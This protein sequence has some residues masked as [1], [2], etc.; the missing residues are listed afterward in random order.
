MPAT[1]ASAFASPR[2]DEHLSFK[3][4]DYMLQTLLRPCAALRFRFCDSAPSCEAASPHRSASAGPEA[5]DLARVAFTD[6]QSCAGLGFPY[7]WDEIRDAVTAFRSDPVHVRIIDYCITQHVYVRRVGLGG[8][9]TTIDEVTEI[10]EYTATAFETLNFLCDLEAADFDLPDTWSPPVTMRVRLLVYR[11][12]CLFLLKRLFFRAGPG[13][14]L[15][16]IPL[17]KQQQLRSAYVL[18]RTAA[19]VRADGLVVDA[20][21]PASEALSGEQLYSL[22][23]TT[24]AFLHDLVNNFDYRTTLNPSARPRDGAPEF[25]AIAAYVEDLSELSEAGAFDVTS[26]D[27]NSVV[28]GADGSLLNRAPQPTVSHSLSLHEM[29]SHRNFLDEPTFIELSKSLN[30]PLRFRGDYLVAFFLVLQAYAPQLGVTNVAIVPY[31]AAYAARGNRRINV[32]SISLD[33]DEQEAAKH[34]GILSVILER[35]REHC[36]ALWGTRAS[37]DPAS[38]PLRSADAAEA[39]DLWG[40]GPLH[41][42]NTTSPTDAF[43]RSLSVLRAAIHRMDFEALPSLRPFDGHARGEPST[44]LDHASFIA[45]CD[46]VPADLLHQISKRLDPD[47]SLVA[48]PSLTLESEELTFCLEG[49]RALVAWATAVLY[50]ESGPAQEAAD[51]GRSTTFA[52]A[53]FSRCYNFDPA[54]PDTLRRATAL[55]KSIL[56]RAIGSWFTS[57]LG[58]I[59]RACGGTSPAAQRPTTD[60]QRRRSAPL[61][62][63]LPHRD[64]R[65]VP[66]AAMSLPAAGSHGAPLAYHFVAFSGKC[67]VEWGAYA[68]DLGRVI[69]YAETSRLELTRDY[70]LQGPLRARP[71]A[72]EHGLRRAVLRDDCNGCGH[73]EEGAGP[74]REEHTLQEVATVGSDAPSAPY[75]SRSVDDGYPSGDRAAEARAEDNTTP[76]VSTI[77]GGTVDGGAGGFG[78]SFAARSPLPTPADTPKKLQQPAPYRA[79]DASVE[80]S[81]PAS[82]AAS[83]LFRQAE[84]DAAVAHSPPAPWP[85][86]AST[87]ERCG[88][89]A[90]DRPEAR[91]DLEALVRALGSV[92]VGH[93]SERHFTARTLGT[94]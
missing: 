33:L 92:I 61:P 26:E 50:F 34:C 46:A 36:H 29:T 41:P 94:V 65:D 81:M 23:S 42:L 12:L 14:V 27:A 63:P 58:L 25:S 70:V 69:D 21:A 11:A 6:I 66:W 40:F 44:W 48:V 84:D 1:H 67:R 57:A 17:R 88:A 71:F 87:S 89:A 64:V 91:L 9:E 8:R 86:A 77:L 93:V 53:D 2:V 13:I 20:D 16:K 82:L 22:K 79:N 43:R 31:D 5:V 30:V 78:D 15:P 3:Y 24:D 76:G 45:L 83:V 4:L 18:I 7:S 49:L 19:R 60:R 39:F 38:L 47:L 80:G 35:L 75:G 72:G 56:E 73:G 55:A 51:F 68:V 85:T 28:F 10:R 32:R 74:L 59:D 52:S 62:P 37:H 54:A 90:G